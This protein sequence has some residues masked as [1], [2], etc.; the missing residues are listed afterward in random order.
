MFLEFDIS[1]EDTLP[2]YDIT[3]DRC[4]N[5]FNLLY[6]Y[7][8]VYFYYSIYICYV[9]RVTA[10]NRLHRLAAWYNT[11]GAVYIRM[12]SVQIPS[13]THPAPHDIPQHAE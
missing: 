11:V 8:S 6:I 4:Y 12:F 1:S 3:V 7:I 9:L 2:S 5:L 13:Y 10:C